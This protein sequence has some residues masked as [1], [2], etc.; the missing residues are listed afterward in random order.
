MT[1]LHAHEAGPSPVVATLFRVDPRAKPVPP[2]WRGP[3]AQWLGTL[4]AAGQTRQTI[5]S[6]RQQLSAAARHLPTDPWSVTPDDLDRYVIAQDWSRETRRTNYAALRGFYRWAVQAGR[7]HTSPAEHLPRVRAS[8]PAPRPAPERIY[9]A[10]KL[11]ADPR[12]LLIIRLAGEAGLR[13]VE[14]SRVHSR[15][16]VEDLVGWSLRVHGKGEKVRTVPIPD[17]LARTIRDAAGWLFPGDDGGHLSARWV[18]KLATRVLADGWTLHTLRH[19][20]ATRAYGLDFDLLAVQR[21]LGHSSPATTQRYV[22]TTAD[23]MRRAASA[24]A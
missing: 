9:A 20:F 14:V 21:L 10:A 7:I 4:I 19:R 12:T 13:R 15:D 17:D 23:R 2:R 24:A 6:R 3:L 5:E 1:Q 18:G 11:D 8:D 22:P 16:L